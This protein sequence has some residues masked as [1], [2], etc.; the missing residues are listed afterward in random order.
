MDS[1]RRDVFHKY[2]RNGGIDAGQNMFG[3]MDHATLEEKNKDEIVALTATSYVP[4]NT[5]DPRNENYIV[6]FMGCLKS[7]L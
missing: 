4:F 5:D 3:G 6:D 2:L 7:F 1:I